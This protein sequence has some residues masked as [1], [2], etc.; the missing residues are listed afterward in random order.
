[1]I[2]DR[3]FAGDEPCTRSATVTYLWALAGRPAV[4]NSVA[5]SDVGTDADYAQA[6]A[7]AVEQGITTGTS[8]T[9]FTP[10]ATCTRGQIVTFL[11]R[12]LVK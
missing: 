9:T 1:M 4:T 6:V 10:D 12:A 5:F 8:A 7:W 11:Y 2:G 3:W